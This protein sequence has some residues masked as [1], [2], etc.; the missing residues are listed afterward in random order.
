MAC[1]RMRGAAVLCALAA[2]T[3][4]CARARAAVPAAADLRD[5]TVAVVPSLDSAGFFITLH[6]GLFARQG[7]RVRFIPAVS[8]ETA[9]NAQALGLPHDEV[10][11]SCGNYVWHFLIVPRA[12]ATRERRS[13]AYHMG[14]R[15]R[16]QHYPARF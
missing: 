1:R 6:E 13:H 4:G 3:A 9:I 14:L 8:S 7:L 15:G 10:D 12:R 5:L 11:I 2:L 16:P